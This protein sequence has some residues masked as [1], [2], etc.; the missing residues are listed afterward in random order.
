M[1]RRSDLAARTADILRELA[2][3]VN[4]ETVERELHRIVGTAGS[5]GLTNGSRGAADLLARVHDGHV[6][7]LA[8]ELITLAEIFTRSVG[9]GAL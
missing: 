5:Y 2:S 7:D 8:A 3:D 1:R 9:D 6:F 4:T